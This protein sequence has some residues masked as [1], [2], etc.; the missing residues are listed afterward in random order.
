MSMLDKH[1]TL[2]HLKLALVSQIISEFIII[3]HHS[4][5]KNPFSKNLKH[6]GIKMNNK[7]SFQGVMFAYNLAPQMYLE[8]SF[9]LLQ[10]R[11]FPD[12]S[13]DF[14]PSF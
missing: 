7:N 3:I 8:V 5:T 4:Y 9:E 6:T 2:R 10:G 13:G 14:V 12:V 11:E 1:L